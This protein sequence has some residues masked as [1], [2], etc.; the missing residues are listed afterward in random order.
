M[1]ENDIRNL[2]GFFNVQSCINTNYTSLYLTCNVN[3]WGRIFVAAVAEWSRYHIMACLVTSSSP[4][5]LKT[6]REGQRCT[7]NRSRA[8]TSS[9]WCGVVAWR[10]RASSGVVH[11]T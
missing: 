6:C 3:G 9:R 8:E 2:Y 1:H 11:V 4:V 7:L 5:L 10:G